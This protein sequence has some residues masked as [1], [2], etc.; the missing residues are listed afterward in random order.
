MQ[1]GAAGDI[2]NR[3]FRLPI[4]SHGRTAVRTGP[5]VGQEEASDSVGRVDQGRMGPTRLPRLDLRH[6][7]APGLTIV[8]APRGRL[9]VGC[10]SAYSGGE[11]RE[12]A[13]EETAKDSRQEQAVEA[14][15]TAVASR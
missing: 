10:K 5:Y 1:A 8:A 7:Q 6:T 12:V 14:G 2:R 9:F 15:S 11:R 13:E 3:K 4:G